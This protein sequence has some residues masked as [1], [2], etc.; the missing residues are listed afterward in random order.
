[1]NFNNNKFGILTNWK[2][3]LFL[4]RVETSDRKTLEYHLIELDGPDEPISML[5]AWVG[6]V[7]LAEDDDWFYTSPTIPSGTNFGT[8]TTTRQDREGAIC[9]TQEYHM[10]PVNGKYRSLTLDFR[11]CR[12][13]PSSAR[14]GAMGCVVNT[15][16]LAPSVGKRDLQVVCK[17]VDIL[18]YP[19]AA[20]WLDD[21]VRAYAAL[22]NLQGK[23]IPTLYGF[24]E[25]WGVLRFL[26]LE[27]VGNAISEDEKI[28]RTLRKNMKAAL[29]CIHDA[30]FVHG[31]VARRNFCRTESGDVLL[32][33]LE[34]CK[35]FRKRSQL[36][37]EMDEVDGL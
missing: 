28:T 10:L 9:N 5:K 12:F 24:Y 16:F 31:D 33:D 19:I 13:D 8:S 20:N 2:R 25:I 35:R 36:S 4:H 7:L 34:R 26:A 27:P 18:R 17:V 22:R 37:D 11:L 21:E 6:M 15:Q 14:R 23:V 32:V 29:Q 30:G 3:A 1:M